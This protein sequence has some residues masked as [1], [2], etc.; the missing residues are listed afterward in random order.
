MG[1]V[2]Y[3]AL[4]VGD[5]GE[6]AWGKLGLSADNLTVHVG[7]AVESQPCADNLWGR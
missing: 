5:E 7:P 2:G 4:N 6:L 3:H 1:P